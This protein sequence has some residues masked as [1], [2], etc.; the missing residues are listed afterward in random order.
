M[1]VS[2]PNTPDTLTIEFCALVQC[3]FSPD[4]HAYVASCLPIWNGTSA[5]SN[6]RLQS[7]FS[8]GTVIPMLSD[9]QVCIHKYVPFFTPKYVLSC[10]FWL[11]VLSDPRMIVLIIIRL[12]LFY[13]FMVLTWFV[14]FKILWSDLVFLFVKQ[15][16]SNFLRPNPSSG[17][18]DTSRRKYFPSG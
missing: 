1:A 8:E 7:S 6:I 16:F 14:V 15:H 12:S 18:V 3:T 13:I 17:S 4:T 11:I 2:F 9:S 10:W 5:F